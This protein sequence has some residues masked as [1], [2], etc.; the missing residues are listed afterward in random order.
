MNAYI[1]SLLDSPRTKPAFQRLSAAFP[2]FHW[3]ISPGVRLEPQRVTYEDMQELECYWNW[4]KVHNGYPVRA[5][6]CR[7]AG[8][9]ALTLGVQNARVNDQDF[10]AV[11]EDDAVPVADA[12]ARLGRLLESGDGDWDCL[13]LDETQLRAA[14]GEDGRLYG[15]RLTTGYVI[16]TCYA[17]DILPRLAQA[18]CELDVWLER[19]MK[20]GRK[21]YSDQIVYQETGVSEINGSMRWSGRANSRSSFRGS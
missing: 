15:A 17:E 5:V 18:S 8:L 2:D 6:G 21:F 10:F 9:Q 1:I 4:E 20:S 7:L 16:R 19:E 12:A 3:L 11:F 14:K 13:W